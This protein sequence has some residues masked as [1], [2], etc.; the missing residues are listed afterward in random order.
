MEVNASPDDTGSSLAYLPAPARQR[1]LVRII[2]AIQVLA[3]GLAAPFATLP[4]PHLDAFIPTVQGIT[5]VND[6]ITSILLFAQCSIVPSRANLVLAVGYLFTALIVI[7]HAL[8]FP[9]AFA[10]TGLLGAGLQSTAWLYI[11]WHIVTPASVLIYACMKDDTAP[12]SDGH[13]SSASTIC[14]SIVIVVCLVGGFTWLATAGVQYLPVLFVDSTRGIPTRLTGLAIAT[15]LVSVAAIVV[16]W[17]RRRS[18][19]DY[20]LMLVIV[21]LISELSLTGILVS[22]R[23]S[24]GF[25][26]ARLFSLTTSV[27]VLGLL[28]SEVTRLY[29]QLARSNRMLGRERNNKLM[30]LEA[31]TASIAHEVRQ[32]LGAIALN[33]ETALDCIG[34][35]PPDVEETRAALN[36][37]IRDGARVGQVL[38]RHPRFVRP[39][40]TRQTAD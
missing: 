23:F 7:P 11:I 26:T 1:R 5:F 20:W 39:N 28:L 32:P 24:L 34:S 19:L 12:E 36:D 33:A 15:V 40:Q 25:Y 9:G 29:V 30:N 2:A 4:L 18:L 16:L 14:W 13:R 38:G 8:T 27:L 10:P 3:F 17:M 35:S 21:A 31:L 22:P 6:L 37:I